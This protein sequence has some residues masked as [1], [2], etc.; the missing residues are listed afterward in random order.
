MIRLFLRQYR[1]WLVLLMAWH[2]CLNIVLTVDRGFASVSLLYINILWLSIMTIC[3]LIIYVKDRHRL[4]AYDK[5]GRDYVEMVAQSYEEQLQAL[6][7]EKEEQ[8][9]QLLE[10][11]DELLA[12][13]HDMKSPMTA[14]KLVHDKLDM[15][16]REQ[17]EKEWLRLYL[18][19]DRQLH[20]TRIQ[21]IAQDNR[22]EPIPLQPII[23]EE[24]KALRTW[25][26]EKQLA[27]DV[28]VADVVVISDAKWLGFI[29]RQILSNAVK[30][31]EVGANIQIHVHQ[32]NN[33]T[34]L[35][36]TDTGCGIAP[37]DLPRVFRKSYTGTIGRETKAA[38][39]MGL[40]LAKQ[41]ATALHIDITI[42]SVQYE[43][44]TVTLTF[45]QAN[46]YVKTLGM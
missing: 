21:T 6:R 11:K 16:T 22:L 12:W 36:V 3:V 10:Q 13:V 25:C 35:T 2:I 7:D 37:A 41:A 43:G 39:G 32:H 18:L 17:A 34:Q 42:A 40:Y 29:M 5:K 33:I 23:I 4:T 31:S 15:K 8:S 9:L 1:I 46:D 30:Y 14:L 19:L 26:F 27:I 38:T 44:T 28:D 20:A 45:Q 24:I